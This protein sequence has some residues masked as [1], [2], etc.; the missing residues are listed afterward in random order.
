[1]KEEVEYLGHALTSNGLKSNPRLVEAVKVYPQPQNVKEVRQFLGL[2]SYYRCFIEKFA[3]VVQPLTALTRNNIVFE[4]T[5]GC[6]EL[7]DGLKQ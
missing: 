6:Q 4:W 2:S 1:M 3:A 5:A 7:F